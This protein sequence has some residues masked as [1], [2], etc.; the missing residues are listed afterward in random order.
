MDEGPAVPLN[1]KTTKLICAASRSEKDGKVEAAIQ[2]YAEVLRIDSNN[3]VAL[4]NLALIEPRPPIR[5][6]ATVKKPC[7]WPPGRLD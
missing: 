1:P 5:S 2:Q 3:P 6:C 4:N 7:K